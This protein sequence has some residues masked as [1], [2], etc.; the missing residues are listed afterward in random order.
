MT[1]TNGRPV[2][3]FATGHA[4]PARKTTGSS[5]SL[6]TRQH[7]IFS[8]VGCS[9]IFGLLDD[10]AWVSVRPVA[11][12]LLLPRSMRSRTKPKLQQGVSRA[13]TSI[14]SSQFTRIAA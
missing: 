1:S 4:H 5:G 7:Y 14:S 2:S 11:Q 6:K 9:L 12:F 10:D 13:R 8:F 3:N